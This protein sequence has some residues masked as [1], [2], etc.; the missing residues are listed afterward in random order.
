MIGCELVP[1]YGHNSPSWDTALIAMSLNAPQRRRNWS[2]PCKGPV[3]LEAV[4]W[5][6]HNPDLNKMKLNLFKCGLGA[7][8]HPT[9]GDK[10][11]GDWET[12]IRGDNSSFSWDMVLI[13]IATGGYARRRSW[14]NPD[15]YIY[16][17]NFNHHPLNL[18]HMK[19]YHC[20]LTQCANPPRYYPTNGDKSAGDWEPV[21]PDRI[22][23]GK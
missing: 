8:Y 9:N 20:D 5:E 18:N 17:P 11:A 1:T 19:L 7:R 22:S 10:S 23:H 21:A 16:N 14:G 6:H 13:G 12:T 3:Y 2:F 15:Y 4:D